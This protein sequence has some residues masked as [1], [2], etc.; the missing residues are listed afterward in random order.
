MKNAG[1]KFCTTAVHQCL[2]RNMAD[3]IVVNSSDI[4]SLNVRDQFAMRALE[5]LIKIHDGNITK[6]V[7][8]IV[9]KAYVYAEEMLNKS[10]EIRTQKGEIPDEEEVIPASDTVEGKL[11][12]IADRLGNTKTAIDNVKDALGETLKIDNPDGDKLDISGG[13]GG[14]GGHD[15]NFDNVNLVQSTGT[16]PNYVVVYETTN[17]GKDVMKYKTAD[18]IKQIINTTEYH[19]QYTIESSAFYGNVSSG[20]PASA[21]N[22]F[23]AAVNSL[24]DAK[25]TSS[26]TVFKNAVDA[27]LRSHNLIS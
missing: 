10:A 1:G 3:P 21:A 25:T 12:A 22:N 23:K 24:I 8:L 18:L 19:E 7:S 5:S 20:T 6:D 26:N 2:S 14:G 17:Y 13:G 16:K 11:Q 9:N 4:T 15:M 27:I